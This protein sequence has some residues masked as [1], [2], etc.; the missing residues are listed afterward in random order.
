MDYFFDITFQ[1]IDSPLEK[2]IIRPPHVANTRASETE[3]NYYILQ[4]KSA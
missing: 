4:V 3:R 2:S 1:I